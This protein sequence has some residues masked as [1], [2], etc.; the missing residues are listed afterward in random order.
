MITDTQTKTLEDAALRIG[1]KKLDTAPSTD[2][3]KRP[4]LG[5]GG[6]FGDLFLWDTAFTCMW[7]MHFDGELPVADSLDNFYRVQ[8]ETGFIHRQYTPDGRSIFL[9]P[10]PI[11]WA[12]P[13]L[14][15]AE[16]EYFALHGDTGRLERVYAHLVRH[17]RACRERWR[18]DDGLY[19]GCPLGCGMDNLPRWPAGWSDD[20][21][22]IRFGHDHYL[23]R[24]VNQRIID[25]FMASDAY[26][27]NLQGR[28][29][30][31]SAQMALDAR[32]LAAMAGAIGRNDDQDAWMREHD[33]LA[34][35]INER[36]WHDGLG[37]YV[38]LGH[39]EQIPRLHIGG[40]WPLLAGIVPDDRVER[41]VALLRDERHFDR[42]TPI[43]TLAAS[44]PEYADGGDYWLGGV[45]APTNFMVLKGLAYVGR[46]DL[47]GDLAARYVDAVWRVYEETRTLW[48]NYDPER[49][50]RG[51]HSG[52]DF[53]GWTGLAAV[54]IPR[55]FLAPQP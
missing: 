16:M 52:P 10:H 45:W 20:G 22:G 7:A 48:E 25:H 54:S 8:D 41:L 24:A 27:W 42:P 46:G 2:L 34:G 40:F 38:D 32:M 5:T 55:E 11:S 36:M 21:K 13:V 43:P 18:M 17:H 26:A 6:H 33:E 47:A 14:T 12:P 9:P 29:I 23:R 39:G 51:G 30:D 15:W 44:E 35:L 31:M 28:F 1:L 19:T 4:R 3:V 50:V 37:A 49:P 53:C